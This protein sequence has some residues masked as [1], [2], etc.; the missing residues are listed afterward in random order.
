MAASR[1][2]LIAYGPLLRVLVAE[3]LA[4]HQAELEP[5]DADP[6]SPISA[7]VEQ[8]SPGSEAPK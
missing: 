2:K 8:A 7:E 6:Q 5:A 3:L 4:E 1:E